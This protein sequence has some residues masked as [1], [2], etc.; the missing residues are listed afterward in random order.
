MKN[1]LRKEDNNMGFV[2]FIAGALVGILIR[3]IIYCVR[4]ASGTIIVNYT[5]PNKD[6][7]RIELDDLAA[8]DTKSRVVLTITREGTISQK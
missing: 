2:W 6:T 8:L 3:T 7:Y 5:D 1:V 4:S